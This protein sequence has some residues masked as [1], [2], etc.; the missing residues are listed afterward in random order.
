MC[1][2]ILNDLYFHDNWKE[3]IGQKKISL[4]PLYL[5]DKT[6]K[7]V[8]LMHRMFKDVNYFENEQFQAIKLL[9]NQAKITASIILQKMLI[10]MI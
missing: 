6:T 8:N 3:K 7:N 2:V 10:S 5:S 1:Y 4:K 9:Y